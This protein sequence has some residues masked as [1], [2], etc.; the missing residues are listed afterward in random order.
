MSEENVEVARRALEYWNRGD[1]DAFMEL[2]AD[3]AVLRPAEGWPERVIYGKDAMRSWFE[4]FA[5]TV[6]HET[7]IE[8]LID[9]GGAGVVVR[10]RVHVTGGLSGIETHVRF[11]QVVIGR[12]GKAVLIE[13]FW[14]HQEALEAA[15][16]SE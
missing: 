10:A 3:D 2:I 7:V 11:S 1:L 14:D 12:K 4:G 16:L 6:G 9:A 8:E 5:E 13:Y 15:G